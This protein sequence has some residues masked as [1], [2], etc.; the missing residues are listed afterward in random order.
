VDTDT[1]GVNER[2]ASESEAP[3]TDK[4]TAGADLETP[5]AAISD[6][7]TTA[8]AGSSSEREASAVPDTVEYSL[9]DPAASEGGKFEGGETAAPPLP[10]MK[11]VRGPDGGLI[12]MEVLPAPPAPSTEDAG[13]TFGDLFAEDENVWFPSSLI[14][15][16]HAISAMPSPHNHVIIIPRH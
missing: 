12:P 1:T 8:P 10:V 2:E 4:K 11:L 13:E 9:M 15:H 3:I 16:I 5:A 6:S 14:T 7:D